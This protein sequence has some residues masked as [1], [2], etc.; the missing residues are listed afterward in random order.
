LEGRER[1]K[2]RSF[3]TA[4]LEY[5]AEPVFEK[6]YFDGGNMLSLLCHKRITLIA[7]CMASLIASGLKAA[8][9][10]KTSSFDTAGSFD[11]WSTPQTLLKVRAA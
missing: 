8:I 7:I 10:P 1:L 5:T 11:G 3:I 6:F 4:R 9:I 2:N